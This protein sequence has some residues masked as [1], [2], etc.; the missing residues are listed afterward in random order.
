[1]YNRCLPCPWII[2]HVC[3]AFSI[4]PGVLFVSS[5]LHRDANGTDQRTEILQRLIF[6]NIAQK[7]EDT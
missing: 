7:L 4:L 2:A 3:I 5:D 6:L 1:M